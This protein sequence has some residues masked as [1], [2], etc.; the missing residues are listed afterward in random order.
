VVNV[1]DPGH[2][3]EL[4]TLD[5]PDPRAN[6]PAWLVFVK[7]QGPKCPGNV[8]AHPGTTTQEVLRACLDRL[9]Y[10]NVQRPCEETVAVVELLRAAVGLL[11]GRAARLKGRPAPTLAEAVYGATC[12]VCGH[13]GCP[14][15]KGGTHA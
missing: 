11:E 8:G 1:L 13:V 5:E 7:R 14:G 3:Y 12:P 10:V 4:A 2:A 9:L 6:P 15:A